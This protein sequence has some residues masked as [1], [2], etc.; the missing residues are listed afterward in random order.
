MTEKQLITHEY[1]AYHDKYSSLYNNSVVLMMVGS[2]LELYQVKN[3]TINVGPD[4]QYLCNNILY[5]QLT[6]KNKSIEEISYSNPLMAGIPSFSSDKYIDIL[7]KNGYTVIIIDQKDDPNPLKKTKIRYE[8]EIISPSTYINYENGNTNNIH[9]YLLVIYINNIK[10]RNGI[11]FLTFHISMCDTLTGCINVLQIINDDVKVIFDEFYRILMFYEPKEL[12]IFGNTGNIDISSYLSIIQN[13]N[14]NFYNNIDNYNKEFHKID[15]QQAILEKVY[16]QAKNHFLSIVEYINL[17]KYSDLIISLCFLFD[18]LYKHNPKLID[19]LNKPNFINDIENNHRNLLLVNNCI[20]N[21]NIISQNKSDLS[22]F[23]LLNHCKT[24]MGIRYLQFKLLHPI[25]DENML[26]NYYNAT[27][28]FIKN[29]KISKSIRNDL[30]LINDIEKLNRKMKITKLHPL[31]LLYIYKSLNKV[32][33]IYNNI[34]KIEEINPIINNILEFDNNY[35]LYNELTEFKK[36]FN[37]IFIVKSMNNVKIENFTENIFTREYNT[38]LFELSNKINIV[39][40]YFNNLTILL[41]NFVDKYNKKSG[42]NF[43]KLEVNN[44]LNSIDRNDGNEKEFLKFNNIDFYYI[45]ITK[46]RFNIFNKLWCDAN[47]DCPIKQELINNYVFTKFNIINNSSSENSTVFKLTFSKLKD[48][49]KDINKDKKLLHELSYNK[50]INIINEIIYKYDNLIKKAISYIELIDYLS[51]NAFI[52][53]KYNYIKPS[54]NQQKY[55]NDECSYINCQ[56][57]RHP[58]IEIIQNDTEYIPNDIQIGLKE[59][60]NGYLLYGMNMVGKSSLLKSV[61]IALIMAQ[62]GMFCACYSL[63]FKPYDYIF[64]HINNQDNIFKNLSLYAS[65]I[66]SIRNF[67]KQMN[68]KS[69]VLCDELCNST[70]PTSACSL[71]SSTLNSLIKKNVSFIFTSHFHELCN[72]SIIK[73]FVENKSLYICHLNVEYDETIKNFIF[74]RK[75]ADGNG[76]T[77]YGLEIAKALDL[78]SVDTGFLLLANEI[79]NEILGKH[80]DLVNTKKSQYNSSIY[81]D[82]CKICNE[83]IAEE[84]HHIK[85]QSEC[86]EN[87]YVKTDSHLNCHK[88][89]GIHKNRKYNLLPICEKCHDNIHNGKIKITY[90]KR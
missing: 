12:V 19:N 35:N 37:S 66:V 81:I 67:L 57:L 20:Q 59:N 88:S 27:E 30:D 29:D 75:L 46:A 48:F 15:Y 1:I 56:G 84:V 6:R 76:E 13:K 11:E 8:K 90:K 65:D 24:P 61:G 31:E 60:Y 25:T 3:E 44:K 71:V 39:V 53:T 86:D 54:I 36:Y 42:G 33:H 4:L 7:I 5:T 74:N 58:L 21:L 62:A 70:E 82:I 10:K 45:T 28:L 18:F 32:L 40:N 68:N 55:N 51:N 63:D 50:Y 17:E 72:I 52:A 89:N 80:N 41:N 14:I 64:S 79:R 85:Y 87:G 73:K 78:N 49:G 9:N 47:D 22:L 2:F 26:Y 16:K 38:E 23:K 69:I 77:L 83:Q 34:N 43:F